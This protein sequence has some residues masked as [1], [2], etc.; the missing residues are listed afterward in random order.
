M[1]ELH[2]FAPHFGLPNASPFCMKVEAFLRLAGIKYDLV[3]VTNPAKG[4]YGKA[5]WIVDQGDI[6]PDS[7]I[8]IEHLNRKHAYPLRNELDEVTLAQHHTIMRMLD[9]STNWVMAYERWLVPENAPIMR[10]TLF[11]ALP[12]LP[13]RLVFMMVQ[14]G[15]RKALHGQGTG[16]LSRDEIE[17]LGKKDID[18]LV[19]LLGDKP[20]FGG[21]KAAEI[22]A[23]T[24]AYIAGF[25]HVPIR[26]KVCDYI[27]EQDSLVAYSERLMKEVFPDFVK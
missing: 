3:E 7:R 23:T 20:Y 12:P 10:D 27:R 11:E 13:R 4:P 18:A 19:S 17:L 24:L 5:P 6:F 22:D 15:M 1:I 2:Q 16:R 9:E 26:S 14:K 21:D 8:I 25:I